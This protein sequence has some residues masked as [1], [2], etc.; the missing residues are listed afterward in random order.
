MRVDMISQLVWLMRGGESVALS[1]SLHCIDNLR[2][3]H[4]SH[5]SAHIRDKMDQTL[6]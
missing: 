5:K 1:S 6:P 4:G 2:G 3:L